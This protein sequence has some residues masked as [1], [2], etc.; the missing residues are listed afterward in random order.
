MHNA[1]LRY[2]WDVSVHL[3]T[4]STT[5]TT[6]TTAA[7]P[8]PEMDRDTG[9]FVGGQNL[10][11]M[12]PMLP[13]VDHKA[14]CMGE[15][16]AGQSVRWW[17][18]TLMGWDVL[19]KPQKL[20]CCIERCRRHVASQ[21]SMETLITMIAED[22]LQ[23]RKQTNG[24]ENIWTWRDLK[25]APPSKGIPAQHVR[26]SDIQRMELVATRIKV[27]RTHVAAATFGNWIRSRKNIIDT[28]LL[29]D[30]FLIVWS[31]RPVCPCQS[32]WRRALCG[33]GTGQN[34]W[35]VRLIT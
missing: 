28:I 22:K 27:H 1:S 18:R 24:P 23:T 30:V 6:T 17:F 35:V 33:H 12:R 19:Y 15:F 14:R 31:F 10:L 32:A 16:S 5:V 34:F 8:E 29:F 11:P 21:M 3:A 4:T 2:F 7:T 25:R 13:V 20:P 9:G 26:F